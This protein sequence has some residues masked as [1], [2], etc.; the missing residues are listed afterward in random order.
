MKEL[1]ESNPQLREKLYIRGFLLSP[2]EEDLNAYPFFGAWNA[3]P[4][5]YMRLLVHPLQHTFVEEIDGIRMAI[6][7]HAMDPISM[8]FDEGQILKNC[9]KAFI[10]SEQSFWDRF[11]QL[12]GVFTFFVL[13]GEQIW[14]M[15]D[16]SGM[17]T[18]FFTVQGG[19][20][21][22]SSHTMLLGELIGLDKDP[23]V[24]RLIRYRF[25]P[26]LG[27]SLPGD[28]T[29]F[30]DLKR[31]TPNFCY[32]FDEG[33]IAHHRFFTP[34]QI[35]GKSGDE[36]AR[37]AGELLHR[38]MV[39]ISKKWRSPAI[40]LTGGCDSKT[41]LACTNGLYDQFQFYSYESSPSEK[42]DCEAAGEICRALGLSHR[43]YQIPTDLP[44]SEPVEAVAKILRW[45]CGDVIDCNENDVRKRIVLDQINDF[46]VEVK[47][48][49]SEIGRAYFSKRFHGRTEFSPRPA[50]RAC[51]TLYKFFLHNRRLVRETDRIFEQ[52]IRDYYHAAEQD[53]LP[54]FEQFF[55]EFRVP[56]WNG[57]VITGEHRYSSDI[58]IPYNNRLLLTML[59]SVSI[60]DR[61]HDTLYARM[62]QIFDPRIDAT[63]VSVTNL[64]HTDRREKLENLYWVVHSKCPL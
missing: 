61:I 39:L 26:L 52:F 45:N 20:L 36:L 12:T 28:R 19:K 56:A 2:G 32:V 23:Y 64:L 5:G 11:N 46:D 15:G 50:G 9:L 13:R 31:V 27:N 1:L 4:F 7:G 38:T 18:T 14:I 8:E 49:A 41:T 47:S 42:V 21:Y 53:P 22:I 40:S 43:V 30:L 58:T 55:W 48:W 37:D 54:W 16:A 60:E 59:L 62:R 25:F 33:T 24:E 29:Q 3:L 57:L 6:V 35:T 51:T 44:T 10:Q 34:F 63:G 17:Q